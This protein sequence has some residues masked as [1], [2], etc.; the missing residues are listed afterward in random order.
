MKTKAIFKDPL[1]IFDAHLEGSFITEVRPLHWAIARLFI[2]Q[3]I[4]HTKP[5]SH[6]LTRQLKTSS[7]LPSYGFIAAIEIYH[8][9]GHT[10]FHLGAYKYQG[11]SAQ[12]ERNLHDGDLHGHLRNMSFMG[13]NSLYRYSISLFIFMNCVPANLG[14]GGLDESVHGCV[15]VHL[16]EVI[17]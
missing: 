13:S 15:T 5:C 17:C 4:K 2:P 3:S 10:S 11:I 6:G 1:G 9:G 16:K 12:I 8:P 7:S 14:P